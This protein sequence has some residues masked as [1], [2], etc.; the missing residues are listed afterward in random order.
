MPVKPIPVS[1][2]QFTVESYQ[3]YYGKTEQTKSLERLITPYL[4]PGS[5]VLDAC[6]G[7]GEATYFLSQ[8]R[9][10][11]TF[12]GI[13]CHEAALEQARR[14]VLSDRA[15]F[16]SADLNQLERIYGDKTFD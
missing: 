6:C 9:P 5:K 12:L 4:L 14:H 8:L 2:D 3:N 1:R 13:D 11:A 16:E 15:K 10:Q 7:G